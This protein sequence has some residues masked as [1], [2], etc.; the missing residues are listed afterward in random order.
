MSEHAAEHSHAGAEGADTHRQ[1]KW[2]ALWRGLRGRCPKCGQGRLLHG[3]LKVAGQCTACAEPLGHLRS[4]DA[5]A[6]VTII[7]VGHIAMPAALIMEQV[8]H[9]EV[10]IQE[11]I[12]LPVVALL[13]LAL[14]PRSKG[15]VLALLW[16]WKAE[17]SQPTAG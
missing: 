12:W 1:S 15:M 10:W 11:V 2:Q 6:W 8:Y 4:D 3:Y 14:L 16:A 9:P 5:P 7:V 17:G 13:T